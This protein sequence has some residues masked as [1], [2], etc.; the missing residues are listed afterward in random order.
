MSFSESVNHFSITICHVEGDASQY[1]I[2]AA[3][4]VLV[5]LRKTRGAR[6]SV[7]SPKMENAGHERAA[8]ALPHRP[9]CTCRGC[10]TSQ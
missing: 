7:E 2:P 6:V 10:S 5:N 1:L 3:L 8:E 9:G 4:E